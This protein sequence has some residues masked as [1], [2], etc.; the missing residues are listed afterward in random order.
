MRNDW[1]NANVLSMAE[2]LGDQADTIADMEENADVIRAHLA[3]A[4]A[5]LNLAYAELVTCPA[6]NAK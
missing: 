6:R 2:D 1:V 3:R 5:Y 4:I